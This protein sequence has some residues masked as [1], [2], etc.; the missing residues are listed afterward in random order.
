MVSVPRGPTRVQ[1]NGK[2]ACGIQSPNGCGHCVSSLLL[3]L[4]EALNT[5]ET[6]LPASSRVKVNGPFGW[7]LRPKG[8]IS[9]RAARA[10]VLVGLFEDTGG[11]FG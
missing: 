6:G 9:E 2:N 11:H 8:P 5:L 3:G 1:L 4:V 10:A 7:F